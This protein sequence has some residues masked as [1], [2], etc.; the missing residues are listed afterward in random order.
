MKGFIYE[1]YNSSTNMY[2]VGQTRM[3]LKRRDWG[4]K[5]NK[6]KKSYFDN[7]YQ[8]HPEQFTLRP[9]V[10]INTKSKE[11][12]IKVLNILEE[13]YISIYKSKG[14]SLYNILNGGNQGWSNVSPTTSMLK[15]LEEGRNSS[16]SKRKALALSKEDKAGRHSESQKKYQENHP[17][18]YKEIYTNANQRR[19]DAKREWYSKN[20]DRL[21]L[22]LRERRAAQKALSKE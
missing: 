1:Y 12:L 13:S 8:K 21:L 16:N 5:H 14:K 22:K 10:E 3:S 2:Y 7:A 11:L 18:K 9:I 19:K 17:D 20:K 15:A 6:S 4:H